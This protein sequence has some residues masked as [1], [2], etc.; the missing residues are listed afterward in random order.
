MINLIALEDTTLRLS[1]GTAISRYYVIIL[2]GQCLMLK[3]VVS[4]NETYALIEFAYP[5]EDNIFWFID[6]GDFNQCFL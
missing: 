1:P 6:K 3:Q 4:L 2:K 5:V